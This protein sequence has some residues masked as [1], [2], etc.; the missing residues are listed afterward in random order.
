MLN[1]HELIASPAGSF[2]ASEDENSQLCQRLGL[3]QV[4]LR[5]YEQNRNLLDEILNLEN[6]SQGSGQAYTPYVQGLALNHEVYLVTN[7]IHG[8]TQAIAP[9]DG[10]WTIGRDRRQAIIPV[11]DGRLS[12]CHAAIKYD[13][14]RQRFSLID[15]ESTNGS[16]VNGELVRTAVDLRDGDRIRLSSISFTFFVG[17]S[18]V[19]QGRI[20]SETLRHIQRIE[21]THH[22]LVPQPGDS[23]WEG[24]PPQ[25]ELAASP[26]DRRAELTTQLQVSEDTALFLRARNKPAELANDAIA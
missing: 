1:I 19:L 24:Q 16:F 10:I 2:K 4:F 26:G 20:P 6:V 7:L 5:L 9:T 22:R 23:E 15:L 17:T 25:R 3:Y 14:A 12:R 8:R 18:T 11:A 21:A 13:P